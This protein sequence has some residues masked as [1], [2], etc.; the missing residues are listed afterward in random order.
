MTSK[1]PLTDI[2]P[3]TFE[4]IIAPWLSGIVRKEMVAIISY[5]SSDRQRLLLNL[6]GNHDVQRRYLD[7]RTQYLWIVV[8]F[9]VDPID[10]VTELETLIVARVTEQ[11]RKAQTKNKNF[12]S[13]MASLR[14]DAGKIVVVSAYGCESLITREQTAILIWFTTMMRQDVVRLLLFFETNVFSSQAI[15]VLGKVPVFQPRI[16]FL[17]LYPS[18]D[19]QQF[20]AFKSHEW[21][22]R[23]P[24]SVIEA[25]VINC[26]GS[27]YL[28]KEAVWYLRDHPQAT[29]EAILHHPEMQF[30]LLTLWQAFGA[31]E[32]ELVDH[33]VKKENID[34]QRFHATVDY[35]TRTGFVVKTKTNYSLTVPFIA[36]FRREILQKGTELTRSSQGGL[37][38]DGVSVEKH[39]SAAQR[40]LVRYLLE[41][42]N[43]IVS[44]DKI[45]E[46]LWPSNT[47]HHYSDWAIDSQISR[48]RIRLMS[49][50]VDERALRTVKGQGI[51]FVTQKKGTI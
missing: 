51:M 35:L 19:V 25:I 32:Q 46:C 34:L 40:R 10:N 17:N 45:A 7:D 31:H 13:C 15:A 43:D 38:V 20:I 11:F 49:L 30:N 48:L 50:G 4:A 14:H 22:M 3:A 29:G 23:L 18:R 39:F 9:R 5:P 24:E 37:L 2:L 26:G 16:T 41:H 12:V 28:V 6:L 1:K 36:Q 44:R 21:G 47:A 8:D 42:P 27:L 33:I